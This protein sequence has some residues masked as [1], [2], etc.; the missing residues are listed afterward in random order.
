MATEPPEPP[1]GRCAGRPGTA[2]R[3]AGRP[4]RTPR[5]PRRRWSRPAARRRG[6]VAHP[7]QAGVTAADQ[8]R[9]ARL[10]QRPV[11]ELVD[12][13]VGGQVVDAVDRL[14]EPERQ[15]L[16]RGHADEQCAGQAGAAGHRD[17]V[18]VVQADAGG[19]AGALEGRDHRLEVGPAGDLGHD[20]AEPGV[21]LDA[22]RHRVGEQRVA[23]G[24]CPTP[25]SSQEV[26]MP[27]TRGS[28][29]TTGP[30]RGSP[31]SCRPRSSAAAGRSR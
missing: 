24:R 2:A 5:P 9:Q 18:D 26:S 29:V 19:L 20:T 7:Q 8:H 23:R 27:R 10:G 14:A 16:G 12:G 30:S 25:V 21:L 31:R 6:D 17:R 15:R 28:S 1:P 22:A 3:A 13:D 11:L 4:C